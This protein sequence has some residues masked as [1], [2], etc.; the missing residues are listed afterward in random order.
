MRNEYSQLCVCVVCMWETDRQID[1]ETVA[2]NQ[3]NLA[4]PGNDLAV[5]KHSAR[6]PIAKD[7]DDIQPLE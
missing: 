5:T 1:I 2:L 7:Q 6:I 4:T 3:T